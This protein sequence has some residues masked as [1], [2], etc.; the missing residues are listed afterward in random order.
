M[1]EARPDWAPEGLDL[2]VPSAARMY[3]YY[4]GGA[5]NFAVDRE[6]ADQ[7]FQV[8]PDTAR[9]M[10]A[11]RAFLHRSVRYLLS[12]GI[13]Q[14]IDIGSG[15]PTVGNVHE[16]ALSQ[17]P[18]SRVLYV[19]HDPIAVAH[20][21]L[22][23]SGN[24]SA[25][26]LHGD[27]RQPEDILDSPQLSK[28]IDLSQPVAVLMVAVLHFVPDSD[29]PDDAI[30]AFHER[31]VPGSYLALSHSTADGQKST[32]E[33]VEGIYQAAS[34]SLVLRPAAR[35]RELFTGWDLV[36]PGLVW[37]PQWRP[38]WP[39]DVGPDPASSYFYAGVG[40]KP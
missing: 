34:D 16:T 25:K 19:D 36:E 38:D 26:V 29:R 8:I 11:N 39:D 6:L 18:E 2:T 33:Q 21:E 1:A 3:D 30:Q 24:P 10:R 9:I 28:V 20:S 12:Q 7:V 23:L 40:Q 4:L 27:L 32:A 22:I 14:F 35:V 15:I 13:R 37:V 5:H 17:A 31:V